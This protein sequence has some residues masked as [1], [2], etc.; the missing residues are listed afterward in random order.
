MAA[1]LAAAQD[2]SPKQRIKMAR[3]L[4]KQGSGAIPQIRPLLKDPDMEVRDEA[5]KALVRIGTQH[6]LDALTEATRDNDPGIQIRAVDGLVNFYVPGYV[7]YGAERISSAIRNRFDRE[8]RAIIE[9]FVVVRPE[10]LEAV[11]R[12]VEGG[13]SMESRA[14][15]ARA[16][17]I[18]RSRA[19]VPALLKGLKSKDDA[20]IFES[21]IAL[22]KIRDPQAG[23]GVV[24][25]IRDLNER[26]Q[27]AAI[28]TAGL[29]Q[30]RDAIP[31]LQRA[32][33]NPR[34]DKVR[35]AALLALAMLPDEGNR[36]FYESGLRDEDERVRV[37]AAE[38]LGRLRNAESRSMLLKAYDE[39]NNPL[40][41]LALAFALVSLGSGG[42]AAGESP[43]R[44]IVDN[45]NSSKRHEV[46]EA[47]LIELGRSASVR[48]ALHSA[49]QGA[50][51]DEKLGLMRVLSVSGDKSS[52]PYIEPLTKDPDEKVAGEAVRALRSL[53]ARL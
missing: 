24:F 12:V 39:E 8:N 34:S 46:A 47:Y 43:L 20:V 11:A 29:L 2:P 27:L 40:A 30:A 41:R 45:L 6:G 4:A 53:K 32:F 7:S 37:A 26:I 10:V 31:G 5:V 1:V 13:S 33:N 21:L 44:L 9:P 15:A 50:T 25:L 51:R 19:A 35:R 28:E 3:D 17:G 14:N 48:P 23:P 16:A 49:M 52:V 18:L 42:D 22:Q 38:G 36:K